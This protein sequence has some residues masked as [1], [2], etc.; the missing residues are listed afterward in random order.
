ME[1]SYSK[2]LLHHHAASG[3]YAGGSKN[4][5]RNNINNTDKYT[6]FIAAHMHGELYK[7]VGVTLVQNHC[8]KQ[9]V[10]SVCV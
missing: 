1:I 8:R 6:F 9:L 4:K 5:S 3:S 10:V 2:D 7:R